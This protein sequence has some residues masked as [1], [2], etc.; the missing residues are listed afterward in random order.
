MKSLFFIFIFIFSLVAG[1][2]DSICYDFTFFPKNTSMP[3]LTYK[4]VDVIKIDSIKIIF[5]DN[6]DTCKW[7]RGKSL[8][9]NKKNLGEYILLQFERS[10][11]SMFLKEE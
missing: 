4:N 6:K 9:K 3:I 5:L 10:K 11:D 1:I 2:T 7:T 8:I